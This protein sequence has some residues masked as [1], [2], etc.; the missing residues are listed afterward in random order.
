MEIK[1]SQI[2]SKL[3]IQVN[4]DMLPDIFSGYRLESSNN[5]NLELSLFIRQDISV[6]E[7]TTILKE[8]KI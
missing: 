2:E 7:L 4:G 8:P 6:F 1:L 3:L 5:R